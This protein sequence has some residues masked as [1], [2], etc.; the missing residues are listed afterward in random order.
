MLNPRH[1]AGEGWPVPRPHWGL[2]RPR[3]WGPR[4]WTLSPQGLPTLPCFWRGHTSTPTTSRSA[5]HK[6]DST[7]RC[8]SWPGQLTG[9]PEPSEIS[10]LR[11]DTGAAALATQ[12]LEASQGG[13]SRDRASQNAVPAVRPAGDP[14][15]PT[16]C[17]VCPSPHLVYECL[18][19]LCVLA[20]R[21]IA[22]LGW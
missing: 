20:R 6:G 13:K 1:C 3:I 4:C 16:E 5:G 12:G 21:P 9:G 17:P 18:Q 8:W 7:L 2:C 15:L 19:C 22:K 10:G 14:S 11:G